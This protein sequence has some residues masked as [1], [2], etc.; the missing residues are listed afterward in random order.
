MDALQQLVE[1]EAI[2]RLKAR[3]HR[4]QDLK[5]WVGWADVW[6]E[7]ATLKFDGAV[8]TGGADGKTAPP[9]HGRQTIV[10]YVSNVFIPVQSVHHSHMPEIDF[11]SDTE[12]Q[13]LWAM[14]D[15]M[16]HDR[17]DRDVHA[18]GH[19]HETYRKEADGQWRIASSHL[20]RIR[21][22]TDLWYAVG[23]PVTRRR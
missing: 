4:G 18:H 5:D 14:Q 19:Y 16:D 12:A 7:D 22:V 17:P 15:I 3:Y 20:T 8:S 10:D 21:R 2:Y 23:R 11:L 9:L 13:G 1:L 6:T